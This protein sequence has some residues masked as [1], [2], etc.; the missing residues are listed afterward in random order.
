MNYNLIINKKKKA[1]GVLQIHPTKEEHTGS[2]QMDSIF[3]CGICFKPYNHND[4]K[5]LSLP[6]GHSF[7]LECC[8]KLPKHGIIQCPYDKSSHSVNAD[9]LPV[10]YQVLTGL[11]MTTTTNPQH[12]GTA[13]ESQI[14]YCTSHPTKKVKFYCIQDKEMFC[15]KCILKHTQQKHEVINCSPKVLDMKRMVQEMI[16][17]VEVYE[18]DTPANEELYSKLE[19]KVRKKFN[20]EIDRLEKSFRRIME[21]LEIQ[22]QNLYQ[23]MKE[24][25]DKEIRS[26][27]E[28]K[29]KLKERDKELAEQKA[30]LVAQVKNMELYA[31][32]NNFNIFY[33]QKRR[34]L[35][36]LQALNEFVKPNPYFVYFMFKDTI[37][38]DDYGSI[39]ETLFKFPT[40]NRVSAAPPADRAAGLPKPG[41]DL[42]LR[43]RREQQDQPLL[44]RERGRVDHQEAGRQ[45]RLQVLPVQRRHCAN[46]HR[47]PHHGRRLAPQEGRAALP[48][49]EER[50]HQQEPH[51]RVAQRARHH[52]VPRQRVRAGR[53]QRQAA[54]QL[55]GEV[56]RE[57]RQVDPDG[58]HEGEAPL[59]LRL[60]RRRR[61]HLR[62]RRLLRQHRAG[63]QRHHRG[64]RPGEEPLGSPHRPHEGKLALPVFDRPA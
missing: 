37:H 51:E 7:C 8:R 50:D 58:R 56:R 52:D 2:M 62:L 55:G 19:L 12:Q 4:K 15:S 14:Q 47:D 48:H 39:K 43:R 63:D 40:L 9:S 32:E 20:D 44:R 16:N 45:Q 24:Q 41:Q 54:A 31:S 60:H 17:E 59:P 28:K 1:E 53:L 11:P 13:I 10:N 57:A 21:Q 25:I 35:K 42:P 30:D 36:N 22:Q 27:Q 34:E 38:V 18:N 6:C 46:P 26:L 33:E 61:V 29:K 3:E 49:A 23:M 5:P 64:V